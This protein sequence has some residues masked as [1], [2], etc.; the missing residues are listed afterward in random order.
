MKDKLL[1]VFTL[2]TSSATLLCCVL[3][4]AVAAIAGGAAVAAMISNFPFLITISQYKTLIFIAAG[5][6]IVVNALFVFRPKSSLVC[7]VT[8]GKGC[9]ITGKFSKVL[10]IMSLVIYIVGAFFAYALVPLLTYL[11]VYQ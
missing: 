7:A 11:G 8:G 5:F 9:E 2:F 4:A 3:P 6:F 10:L 1:S